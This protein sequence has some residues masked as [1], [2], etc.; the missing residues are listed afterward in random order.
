[1]SMYSFI[2]QLAVMLVICLVLL[3][4]GGSSHTSG[5]VGTS[6]DAGVIIESS[7]ADSQELCLTAC[8]PE[9]T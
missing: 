7:L 3:R 2:P 5:L 9:R 1:M 6:E 4:P 8:W